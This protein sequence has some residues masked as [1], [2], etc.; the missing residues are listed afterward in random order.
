MSR[1][2]RNKDVM[3]K[4]RYRKLLAFVLVAMLVIL[5]GCD[6]GAGSDVSP[7]WRRV[8]DS[9]ENTV[10]NLY[11]WGGDERANDWFD[12][13][14]APQVMTMHGITL[15]RIEME[16]SEIFEILR[17]DIKSEDEQGDIDLLWISGDHFEYAK[18]SDMLY[19]PFASDLPNYQL[20]IDP[21]DEEVMYDN[22]YA[23]NGYEVPF[24]RDQFVMI[25]NEDMVYEPPIDMDSLRKFVEENPGTMTYPAPP[26]ETGS[27]FVRSV[28]THFVNHKKLR[29][30]S[31]DKESVAAL[32]KP[33]MDYL[34][35]IKPYLWKKG[36][37]YPKNAEAIDIMYNDNELTIAMSL[38]QNH[39]V[40]K[41]YDYEYPEG[42]RTQV[43]DK[44]SIGRTNYMAIPYNSTNK[45]G[46][47]MVINACLS[48]DAQ[49]DKYKIKTWGNVPVLKYQKLSVE[50]AKT[51]SKAV[52]KK[53]A[54]KYEDLATNHVSDIPL[55]L[56]P[57]IN[58]IWLDRFTGQ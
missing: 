42:S 24:G 1:L 37:A 5:S 51:L 54:P 33:A 55:D 11:A 6:T 36:E 38:F 28:V 58:E 12:E 56:I 25:Y 10:V 22:G 3:D 40:N 50:E 29:E 35:S 31:R 49:R 18:E 47:M 21:K 44:A 9:G 20:Y 45:A 34:E 2:I 53:T 15:N 4:I 27:T 13:Y 16:Y 32:V 43:L 8:T 52:M 14:L 26:N 57:I 46:S 39:V 23:I 7:K 30:V 48:I 17:D 19:G 41:I